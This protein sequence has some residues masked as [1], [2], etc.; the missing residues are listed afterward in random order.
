MTKILT[1]RW[2]WITCVFAVINIVGLAKIVSVLEGQESGLQVES[3]SPRGECLRES[4]IEVTFDQPMVSASGPAG[5]EVS[6]LVQFDP[7]LKGSFTWTSPRKLT[8]WSEE[9]LAA[10]S[11]YTATISSEMTSLLGYSFGQGRTFKFNT[12]PLRFTNISQVGYDRRARARLGLEFNNKVVPQEVRRHLT[13]KKTRDEN[14]EFDLITTNPG[15]TVLVRTEPLSEAGPLTARLSQNLNA[16]GGGLG[17]A[18]ETTRTVRI[19]PGIHIGTADA[20]C[21]SWGD[22][23]IRVRCTQVPHLETARE[24]LQ[25]SPQVDFTLENYWRGLKLRGK[26]QPGERYTVRFLKGFKSGTGA[27]LGQD[28]TREVVIPDLRPDLRFRTRGHY[29]SPRGNLLIPLETVNL[30]RA[31]VRI[32]KVYHNNVVHYLRD[33]DYRRQNTALGHEVATTEITYP[34]E[35]NAAQ[36]RNVDLRQLLG[37]DPSGVYLISARDPNNRWRRDR[38]LTIISDLGVSVKTSQ[39]DLLVWVNTISEAKPVSGATVTLYSASN[40]KLI[41]GKTDEEGVVHFRDFETSEQLEAYAVVVRKGSDANALVFSRNR[42]QDSSFE[43]GGRPYLREGYE[44]LVYSERGIYRPGE[45]VNVHAIVR[46]AKRQMP[47]RFP[48]TLRIISPDGRQMREY[49]VPLSNEGCADFRTALPSYALTGGYRAKVSVPGAKEAIGS[50][51]FRVEEFV[52]DHLTASVTAPEGNYRAGDTLEFEVSGSHLFGSPAQN[53]KVDARCRFVES[54]F[55]PES[56]HGYSFRDQEKGFKPI[57]KKLG[58]ARL[59]ESGKHLFTLKVPEEIKGPSLVKAVFTANVHEVGGRTVSAGLERQVFPHSVLVG[60]KRK[61]K[62]HS[63]IGKQEEFDCVLLDPD[64]LPLEEGSVSVKVYRII[65]HTVLRR[66]QQGRFRFESDRELKEAGAFN[67]EMQQGTGTCHFTPQECGNYLLRFQAPRGEHSATISFYCGGGTRTVWNMEEPDT[68]ELTADRESYVPGQT[69]RIALKSP[70]PGRALVTLESDHVVSSQTFALEGNTTEISFPVE[71]TWSPGVYCSVTVIRA[72]TPGQEWHGHRAFGIVPL[73]INHDSQRLRVE[74]DVPE[75]IRPERPV[76]IGLRATDG[77]GNGVAAEL[78]LAAVDE[79]ICQMSRYSAPDPIPFFYGKRRLGVDTSDL[80][81]ALMPEVKRPVGSDSLAGGGRRKRH[82]RRLLN[83]IA[84]RRVRTVSLWKSEI[85]TSEDGRASVSFDIP[86]FNGQLRLVAVAASQRRFGIAAKKILVRKPLMIKCSSPRFLAPNDE[87]EVPVTVFNHTGT[88]GKVKITAESGSDLKALSPATFE[89]NVEGDSDRTTRLKFRAPE[90]PGKVEMSVSAVLGDERDTRKV[91]L[92]VRPPATLSHVCGRGEV[93]AG[94][95]AEVDLPNDWVAGSSSYRI[96][97]SAKPALQFG[98]SLSYLLRYPYGCAEQ[99]TSRVF[100]LLCLSDIA[101]LVETDRFRGDEVDPFIQAGIWRLISMQTYDGGFAMW[102]G[103]GRPAP[104]VSV[105]ATHFLLAAQKAGHKVPE[106]NLNEAYSYL[107]TVARGPRR[108]THALSTRAYACYVLAKAGKPARSSTIRLYE[109]RDKLSTSSRFQIAVV[110]AEMGE[111]DLIDELVGGGEVA[112]TE[113]DALADHGF[114]SVVRGDAIL[115]S[116][117]LKL[118]PRSPHVP[119]LA[120][121]ISGSMQ[122]GRWKTT[123]ENAFALLALGRY[124]RKR[125]TE[126][127]DFTARVRIDGRELGRFTHRDQ[128]VFEPDEISDGKLHINVEGE[129]RLYYYW[130]VDGIPLS[131][132]VPEKDRSIAVRRRY[133]NRDGR[134]LDLSEVKQGQVVIAEI[135]LRAE[136]PADNLVVSD[137]LPAGFEIQNP[138]IVTR[139]TE[140]PE[141]T[142]PFNFGSGSEGQFVSR[143]NARRLKPEHLEMRDDRLLLFCDLNDGGVSYYRYILRAVTAGT[144]KLPAVSVACMYEPE[145]QSAHGRG[146]VRIVR[147]Q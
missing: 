124:A 108:E 131:E 34:D 110:L 141:A 65:W 89:K 28:V 145:I 44:A 143:R 134:P 70:F 91:E 111:D 130:T 64:G 57:A 78:T 16:A 98:E 84:A 26:F 33:Q 38:Q 122:N 112:G 46:G 20:R 9:Q 103:G 87:F 97:F 17:L 132:K 48:V 67:C 105:Y 113:A 59:D 6:S 39:R 114:S 32:E 43:I 79:G 116:A 123:Q 36:Q 22:P 55:R 71:Q 115:L 86:R 73:R 139:D 31:E 5:P 82:D 135:W 8:F 35:R 93:E 40:Q 41:A 15:Y 96:R 142:V 144:F 118:R 88:G 99:T 119:L 18:G 10:C 42:V 56:F 120:E 104:Y 137:L 7:P 27:Y 51:S 21:P 61:A 58:E 95:V 76:E 106:N 69:A 49:S 14:V 52:P 68:V 23:Y 47:G 80:Y 11:E 126:T 100:P 136:R 66:D 1:K 121:R 77:G 140:M 81:S 102:P 19:E 125:A 50:H 60:A 24:C 101:T 63:A 83:P 147:E 12:P 109:R 25:I 128:P 3:F 45:T 74:L 30:N 53:R 85:R 72:V 37:G 94:E 133:L 13:L 4:K 138:R 2:F 75:K 127:D 29:L 54:R 90:L 129:G 117:L 92:S 146:E 62:G 107:K